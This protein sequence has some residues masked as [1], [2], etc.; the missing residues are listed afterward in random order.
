MR[1]I[2]FY[3]HRK[4]TQG[5]S[6]LSKWFDRNLKWVFT[7]PTLIFVIL[8]VGFPIIYTLVVSFTSWRM[9]ATSTMEF[10]GLKNYLS[11]LGGGRFTDAIV[12]TF[13]YSAICLCVEMVFGTAI[14]LFLNRDF[15]GKSLVKTAFLLPMVAT[16]VAVGMIWKLMY[17]P[18]IGI[19]NYIIKALGGMRIDFL[20]DGKIALFSL[21]AV[22]IWQWTPFVML[23][24]LAGLTAIPSE[25]LE[26]ACV[27]GASKWQVLWKVQMPL[28]RPTIFTAVLLRLIDVLKTFDIMY[29]MTQGGPG[30]DTETMNILSF[31][32]AFEFMNFGS[33]CS[34]L[35]VFFVI[36]MAIA[37]IT[38]KVKSKMEVEL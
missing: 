26:A 14:A 37:A 35:I 1:W 11:V 6:R 10:I 31:R 25:P 22:D 24:M 27:D 32:E 36:V 19:F 13:E 8:M 12:R 29:S 7:L 38:I 21:M 20:G 2:F 5:L 16:P 28:L 18:S 9:S 4:E 30:F 23:I 15:K 17:D 3:Y 34:M 33:A